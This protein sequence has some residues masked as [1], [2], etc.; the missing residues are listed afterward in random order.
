MR[1]VHGTLLATLL[2]ALAGSLAPAQ[3]KEPAPKRPKLAAGADSNDVESYLALG[4]SELESDPGVAARAFYWSARLQPDRAEAYYGRMVAQLLDDHDMLAI[5]FDGGGNE[6]ERAQD[7]QVDSVFALSFSLDPFLVPRWD[8]T[9]RVAYFE[10][11]AHGDG[12]ATERRRIEEEMSTLGPS[13]KAWLF[14]AAGQYRQALDFYALVSRQSP[15]NDFYLSRRAEIHYRLLESDSALKYY[16]EAIKAASAAEK[17]KDRLVRFYKPK[18]VYEYMAGFVHETKGNVAAAREA[19]GRALTEDLSL[20]VAHQ[21]LGLLALGAGDTASALSELRLGTEI[22]PRNAVLRFQYAAV[23][24]RAGKLPEAVPELKQ[25]IESEPW[26]ADPYLL[27]ARLYDA[28]DLRDDARKLYLDFLARA[29]RT[30]LQ[31][32]FAEGR[33]AALGAA[34]IPPANARR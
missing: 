12:S 29:T 1:S 22:A 20:F 13:W 18:A 8:K 33:V 23:L 24:T 2:V 15:K 31:R 4:R 30:D 3:S 27:L 6:R 34:T 17:N 28:S 26:Y 9:L 19:Y 32:T 10:M 14:Y 7:K 21:R 16:A 11:R 25:V 5:H